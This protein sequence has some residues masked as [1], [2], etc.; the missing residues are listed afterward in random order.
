MAYKRIK[1]FVRQTFSKEHN[2][3]LRVDGKATT[4]TSACAVLNGEGRGKRMD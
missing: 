2:V 1:E 4:R 3:A